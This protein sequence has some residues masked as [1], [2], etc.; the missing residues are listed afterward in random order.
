MVTTL[1]W[2]SCRAHLRTPLDRPQFT[3]AARALLNGLGK[4]TEAT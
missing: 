1:P 4:P 2:F 3:L